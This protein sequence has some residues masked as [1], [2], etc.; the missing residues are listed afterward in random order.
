MTTV[1]NLRGDFKECSVTPKYSLFSRT[2]WILRNLWLVLVV[3]LF[4]AHPLPAQTFKNPRMILTSSDPS[5]VS[6][7][8]L[9]GDGKPDL[10][11]LDGGSPHFVHILLGNGDWT[12]QHGQDI[13]LPSGVGGTITIADV[14]KDGV[15]DLV[16]GGD[17]PQALI[18]VLLGNGDGTFQSPIVT[19]FAP[20]GDAFADIGSVIG[21][22]DF[23][24]D[25]A[26]DLAAA[27]AQNDVVY[28]LL[29]DNTGS[30]T[31]KVAL[32]NGSGPTKVLTGDFNGD[33]HLDIIVQGVFGADATVYLGKGDGTFQAGV[34]YTGPHNIGG[35]ILQDM[36]GDGHPDLV[37]SG[38]ND[39]IDILHGNSDGTFASTSSGGS[40]YGGPGAVLLAVFDFNSDG[41]LDIATASN[42]GISILLGKGHLAYSPPV[43]YSGSPTPIS[44]VIA[45]FNGDGREDFAEIAPG[46]IALIFGAPGGTLQ[47]ADLYD[48]GE[49][50]ALN[51]V[52]IAD[53]NG[54][55]L[56]DIAVNVPAEV[57]ALLLGQS[58]G[59][60]KIAAGPEGT[61]GQL[62]AFIFTGDFNGDGHADL[63]LTG[64]N[65]G[66]T[67]FFGN[68]NGTFAAPVALNLPDMTTFGGATVG[69]F[70]H[71]G[72]TDIVE[73]QYEALDVALG[74][75]NE[76][77]TNK[78]VPYFSLASTG[79][80]VGDFNNDGKLDI[81]AS[82]TEA[83]QLQILLG[84]GDGTFQFGR[85]LTAVNLPQVIATGDFDG[86]GKIDIVACL[87]F[88]NLAQVYF[89][90][91]DGSFQDPVNV[92]LQRQYN[93]MAVADIDGD[94]KP[95]LILSDGNVLAIIR[96][97]GNRTFGPEQHFLAGSIANFA[98]AD[99]NGDGLPD[100]IVAN[101]NNTTSNGF[102][103]TT[104]TV[105][106]NQGAATALS[107]ELSV[108]PEPST[109]GQPFT[110]SLSLT[111]GSSNSPAPTGSVIVSIDGNPIATIPV[112]SLN[113]TYADT[114]S[115][116]IGTGTHTILAAYSGDANY[117]AATF[118][119]QHEVVPIVYPTAT[120]LTATPNP[121]LASQTVRFTA[122][123]TSPGQNANPP[124]GVV[125]TVVFRDGTT[126]LGTAALNTSNIA[127]FDTALLSA[128]THSVTASYLGY[129]AS[130]QQT[131]SFAPS[132]SPIVSVTV[133]SNSTSTS[134]TA[135]PSSVQIGGTVSL[136]AVVASTAGIPTGAVTFLDGNSPLSSQPLDGSGT[137][138]SN[139]TFETSG[140]H[141]ITATYQANA[142][143]ATSTS[144]T[145]NVVVNSTANASQ[146]NT[147]LTAT[148]SNQLPDGINLTATV[149]TRKEVP[150]GQVVFMD[151]AERLGEAGLN[152]D[153]GANF[154]A[155]LVNPGLHYLRAFYPGNSRIAPSVSTTL[156]ERAPATLPDFTLT[157]STT[158]VVVPQGESTSV[159]ATVDPINGFNGAVVLSCASQ[160]P[161]MS[162]RF[163]RSTLPSRLGTSFMII[164]TG[165]SWAES[166]VGHA[167]E[168][169]QAAAMTPVGSYVVTVI[170]ASANSNLRIAHSVLVRI[171]VES[172]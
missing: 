164:T 7:G 58:G 94:G 36:D 49:G 151:G 18:C 152:G 53:F 84:N 23:N 9:N 57:P 10:A 8:D 44:A 38:F 107:G 140:T 125:G 30:F 34:R 39:T 146:S 81:V 33:G 119:V 123:V 68:G 14:N 90:N 170:A 70:N 171:T 17:G 31:L 59:K 13:Q 1:V 108:I 111:P 121:V 130:G 138:I 62:A 136:T 102:N 117:L 51:G 157:L 6:Q 137:A 147:R 165:Q 12:F 100:I 153:G 141:S 69:D 122:T 83:N 79:I 104:V 20:A 26:V 142:T 113:L 3:G 95:D 172:Q 169:N 25:G 42:N 139:V 45:D 48:L 166:P 128:G 110:I 86:D 98:V 50:A 87:G 65:T 22:A 73:M 52:A 11:Y 35:M 47:S 167:S 29:G 116:S 97:T 4:A 61:G 96:Y 143:F 41:I 43:P 145:L 75:T 40:S 71:D 16:L 37:V 91:G 109:Y 99:V 101:G 2:R 103:A 126:N 114:N 131:G 134:L 28:I 56:P 120:S 132:T 155:S 19:Q 74:D 66:G 129:T 78:P 89:G 162:C 161:A 127:T 135:L 150:T 67:V 24:G 115:P 64:I 55:H 154:T 112:T 46:G 15:P 124:N 77:F 63:L 72:T 54:D 149:A 82:Q 5:T 93:R 80:A 144:A 118:T 105:L 160:T 148:L 21:V 156:L 133:N 159:A 106:I 92:P 32:P 158:S 60:F 85:Q 27:D 76:T 163:E 168:R 88:F